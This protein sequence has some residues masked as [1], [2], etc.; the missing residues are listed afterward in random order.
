MADGLRRVAL[1]QLDGALNDHDLVVIG[2]RLMDVSPD[3]DV[4]RESRRLRTL[5]ARRRTKLQT[6]ARLAGASLFEERPRA[7]IVRIEACWHEWRG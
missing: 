7:F 6:E 3:V 5:I 4:G 1:E 2:H